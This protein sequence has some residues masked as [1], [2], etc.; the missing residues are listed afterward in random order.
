[1]KA[2]RDV[3]P[4]DIARLN[5]VLVG[6]PATNSL[7]PRVNA[8][9]PI[10]IE[11]NAIVFGDRRFE[12]NDVGVKCVYPNPLNPKRY[13]VLFSGTTWRGVYQIVGRFGNWFDWGI[14]DGWH[15]QD[16]AIFDDHSYSPE[17]FLAVGYFDNDWKINPAWHVVGDEKLRKARPPRLT[18]RYRTPPEG[19]GQLYLSDLEPA[20]VKP[21][22]GVVARDR[23]FN[24]L[25]LTL[26]E[27]TF[28]RG[29]GV[30]PNCDIG[31]D[32]GGRFPTFE[33]VVGSD[34]EGEEVSEAR[35]CAGTPSPAPSTCPS[36]A[37]VAWSSR[38]IAAAAHAG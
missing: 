10:R 16:F 5:L 21:E 18:P 31:F 20:Y 6:D 34:L 36:P 29:L 22:K 27:R 25:P 33:A 38:S 3:K 37:S 32:L 15:W 30:H 8:E 12:G 13:V 35:A 2:D 1:V 9:L 4:D 7:I 19:I 17:T 11:R 23:S 24:A 26:G 14:L 28:E